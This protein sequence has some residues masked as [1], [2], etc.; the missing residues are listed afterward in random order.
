[1]LICFATMYIFYTNQRQNSWCDTASN[2]D[3]N[4]QTNRILW[5]DR[6]QTTY[7]FNNQKL[8]IDNCEGIPLLSKTAYS[9]SWDME[10]KVMFFE[11]YTAECFIFLSFLILKAILDCPQSIARFWM[12]WEGPIWLN[13]PADNSFLSNNRPFAPLSILCTLISCHPYW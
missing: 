4:T 7:C 2:G 8:H 5:Y 3:P 10:R 12:G 6:M 13:F 11:A 9:T 1:M